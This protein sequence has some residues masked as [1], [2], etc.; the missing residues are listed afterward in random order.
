MEPHS[1]T[2][3]PT[4]QPTAAVPASAS[5][6]CDWINTVAVFP[7]GLFWHV[8]FPGKVCALG[9]FQGEVPNNPSFPLAS[10]SISDTGRIF[11]VPC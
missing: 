1:T 3:F 4:A 11:P 7:L 5:M 8:P 9:S 10:L 2:V 6:L